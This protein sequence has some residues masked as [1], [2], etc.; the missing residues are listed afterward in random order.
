MFYVSVF[1]QIEFY[2]QD[3]CFLSGGV[4]RHVSKACSQN[5]KSDY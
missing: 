2:E 4:L 3:V 5:R 1:L